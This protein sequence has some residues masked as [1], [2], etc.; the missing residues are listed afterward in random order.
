MGSESKTEKCVVT[1]E[2]ALTAAGQDPGALNILGP[3]ALEDPQVVSGLTMTFSFFCGNS[4]VLEQPTTSCLPKAQPMKSVLAGMAASKHVV[5][6]GAYSDTTPKPLQLWSPRD[7]GP[8]V[9]PRPRHLKSDLVKKGTKRTSDGVVKD[10]YS[11]TKDKLKDSQ[12]YCRPFGRA[13][14]ILA[15]TWVDG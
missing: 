5:W 2:R 12:T 6:H 1:P 14:G 7:L 9:R 15:Q 3:P 13:I 4:P 11:G 8:L 10:T